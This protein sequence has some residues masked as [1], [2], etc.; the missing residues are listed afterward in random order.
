MLV[1]AVLLTCMSM[2]CAAQKAGGYVKK[3]P[4]TTQKS[5]TTTTTTKKS[6]TTT[7]KSGGATSRNSGKTT[8]QKPSNPSVSKS[9][10]RSAMS[11][12][13]KARIINN[14]IANMVY[15][16]GGTFTMGATSE[17]GNDADSDEKPPHQVTLSSYYIGKYEVTQE[18]WQA[19]MGS[20]PSNFKGSHRPVE[21]VSWEDCQE[22][23]RRL[24]QKTGRNFRLPTE[25]EW[26]YAARG[27][28]KS[29]GYKYAGGN[30]I[31]DVA[32]YDGNSN[33]QTHDVGQKRSNELGLY[34]M[35]GNVWEWGQDWYG[36]Y[37]SS[38][39]TNPTGAS[40]GSSR[41]FRGGSWY[42][43]ARGC[44]VSWRSYSYP[45]FRY[46]YLGLRLAL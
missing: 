4:T 46:N 43:D 5:T 3:K 34:D 17:Q 21:E 36:S 23:I 25:A 40:T 20:N 22:F 7:Q 9:S 27:G 19:V 18:E 29:N 2:P 14:L 38:S 1:V 33:Y 35:A 37:S 42:F 44:R 30:N 32:W 11:E 12:A 39:L 10:N 15:V 6:G 28:R 45:S 16:E 41:V 13:E 8:Q 26:E 24:N 31:G